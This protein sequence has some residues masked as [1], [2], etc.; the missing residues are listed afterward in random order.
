MK[1]ATIELSRNIG[2][3]FLNE[4]DRLRFCMCMNILVKKKWKFSRI[5]ILLQ[6]M[7]VP[8]I[9]MNADDSPAFTAFIGNY[10]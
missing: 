1:I 8:I 3:D 4:A 2:K 10:R 7:P 5:Q 6:Q 9:M